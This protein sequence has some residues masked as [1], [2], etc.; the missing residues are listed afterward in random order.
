MKHKKILNR[1][2]YNAVP[3][4][5]SDSYDGWYDFRIQLVNCV[6]HIEAREIEEDMGHEIP[7]YEIRKATMVN[8]A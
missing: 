4:V 3:H 8:D 5:L 2:L 6:L 7:K 1:I